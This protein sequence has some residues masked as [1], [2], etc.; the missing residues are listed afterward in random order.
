MLKSA[1]IIGAGAIGRGFVPWVLDAFHIDFFDTNETLCLNIRERSGFN[2]HMSDGK[3]LDTK[4]IKPRNITSNIDDLDI[5]NYDIVFVSVGPRNIIHLPSIL[6][7]VRCPIYSLE[8]DPFTVTQMK[9]LLSIDNIYFGVPDVITSCTASY[10]NLLNDPNCLHTENGILYL[11]KPD[12]T[13]CEL[14]SSL[15]LVQWLDS[16]RMNEEW[17][18]KLF[19]HNTPHCVAA[20]LGH[21]AGCE[22]LHEAMQIGEIQEIING[23]VSEIL[24]TLKLE[25]AHDHQF[26]KNYADKEIKRFSNKLLFDPISR[27]AREPLRKLSQ[28]GRLIGTLKIMLNNGV[29]PANLMLGIAAALKY[30]SPSDK[31]YGIMSNIEHFNIESFL[32]YHLCLDE[33]SVE[34]KHICQNYMKSDKLL[35][36]IFK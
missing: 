23:L 15:P 35:N 4:F 33:D 20:Y 28:G 29:Q 27:V 6:S 14:V 17:D 30:A 22:Y 5:E 3:N 24:V 11:Q 12:E 18:A 31:D 10:D 26:M 13:C 34:S 21:L 16:A 8:N 1:L 7:K 9:S 19:I 2:S 36:E 25:T 32:K